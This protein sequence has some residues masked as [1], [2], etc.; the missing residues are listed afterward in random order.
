MS[1]LAKGLIFAGLL[2]A[3][4]GIV[5]LVV[6]KIPGLG[7][8]P[9]DILI[10]KENVTFYPPTQKTLTIQLVNECVGRSSPKPNR[11]RRVKMLRRISIENIIK[12]PTLI[13]GSQFSGCDLSFG[14][15]GVD[16]SFFNFKTSI[17][18]E[19]ILFQSFSKDRVQKP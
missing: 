13:Y 4:L 3:A 18:S 2:I 1:D 10:K 8:L 15:F 14:E 6:E 5:L 19:L 9:G 11:R 17:R 7:R 16:A 12:P